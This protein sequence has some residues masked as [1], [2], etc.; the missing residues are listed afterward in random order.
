M[1]K[2]IDPLGL[3]S[4]KPSAVVAGAGTQPQKVTARI[5]NNDLGCCPICKQQM[6]IVLAHKT[7]V[8][9]CDEHKVVLPTKD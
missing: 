4:P 9:F 6:P 1:T 2:Y 3:M 5:E 7:P 8:Y